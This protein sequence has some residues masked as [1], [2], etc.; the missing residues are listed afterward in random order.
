M[1]NV[2]YIIQTNKEGKEPYHN[3]NA[4]GNAWFV[5][6][7]KL[8]NKSNTEMMLDKLNKKKQLF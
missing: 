8:V 4:N 5:N 2:K 1:L 3:P 6:D 7:V